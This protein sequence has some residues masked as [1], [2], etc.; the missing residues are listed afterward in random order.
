MRFSVTI[1]CNLWVE[2][3]FRPKA[4]SRLYWETQR[5]WDWIEEGRPKVRLRSK[6]LRLF[7]PAWN[8]ERSSFC[9]VQSLYFWC[10]LLSVATSSTATIS[11]SRTWEQ[12]REKIGSISQPQDSWYRQFLHL[13]H[14]ETEIKV[15]KREYGCASWRGG[16]VGVEPI[17][18]PTT[19]KKVVFFK[20][21]SLG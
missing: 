2:A 9:R 7:T 20:S 11:P 21:F 5:R 4:V 12:K 14:N 19:A 17:F 8:N 16:W 6:D 10:T 18:F 1:T 13:P 15:E 3:F